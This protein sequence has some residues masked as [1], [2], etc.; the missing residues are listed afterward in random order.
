LDISRLW[1]TAILP[2]IESCFADVIKTTTTTDKPVYP[3]ARRELIRQLSHIENRY[4]V[5]KKVIVESFPVTTPQLATDKLKDAWPPPTPPLQLF[6]S[7]VVDAAFSDN[8]DFTKLSSK[9][10]GDLSDLDGDVLDQLSRPASVKGNAIL[11]K[12]VRGL[13]RNRR[14]GNKYNLDKL[15]KA[16]K[17]PAE[18]LDKYAKKGEEL[19]SQELFDVLSGKV[20]YS[21]SS[22]RVKSTDTKNNNK[23]RTRPKPRRQQSN[24]SRAKNL[25]FY[26]FFEFMRSNGGYDF[27]QARNLWKNMTEIQRLQWKNRQFRYLTAYDPYDINGIFCDTPKGKGI[28]IKKQ[29]GFRKFLVAVGDSSKIDSFHLYEF[30]L[31]NAKPALPV[32]RDILNK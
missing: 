25:E 9:L 13:K 20:S 30:Q 11:E 16:P 18:I 21:M 29:E 23:N 28:I 27:C 22:N 4:N 24:V 19:V 2:N 8:V 31:A 12:V 14:S 6:G 5:W 26:N 1:G 10:T 7:P 3:Y 32:C 15:F 17:L